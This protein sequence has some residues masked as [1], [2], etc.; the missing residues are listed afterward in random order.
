MNRRGLIALALLVG[1]CA[2]ETVRTPQQAKTL[3]L[4]SACAKLKPALA[5]NEKMPVEWLAERRGDKWYAW[6]PY[7]PGAQLPGGMGQL[8]NAF[9]HFGAWISPKDGAILYCERGGEQAPDQTRISLPPPP[10][11]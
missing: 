8:Q 10:Q 1:G 2:G 9:G 5:L 6:L 11:P 7:G 3:A 4:A